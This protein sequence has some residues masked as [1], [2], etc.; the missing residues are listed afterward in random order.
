MWQNLYLT[1]V[2]FLQIFFWQTKDTQYNH[3]KEKL[4]KNYNKYNYYSHKIAEIFKKKGFS[5]DFIISY[6]L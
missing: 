2:Q 3:N 5:S 4:K 6:A 1:S